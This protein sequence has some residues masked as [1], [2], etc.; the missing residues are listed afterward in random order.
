[1]QVQEI[2][3]K[4]MKEKD[5]SPAQLAREAGVGGATIGRLL[6]SNPQRLN[7]VTAGRIEKALDLD[8]DLYRLSR[9]VNEDKRHATV[10]N[11]NDKGAANATTQP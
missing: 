11:N 6:G 9:S 5:M 7:I 10:D 2:I 1:M 4:A 3:I 8:V